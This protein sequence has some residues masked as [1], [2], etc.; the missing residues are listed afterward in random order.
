MKI[1][2]LG[3]LSGLL[4]VGLLNGQLQTL[5]DLATYKAQ[6]DH[7]HQQRVARLTAPEGWLSLAGLFWLKEGQ[8]TFGF[9]SGHDIQFP[10]GKQTLRLGRFILE[11][12]RV[13]V[14]LNPSAEV[15][16]DSQKVNECWLKDDSQ[17]KPSR[18]ECGPYLWYIIKR[19]T[20]L[21]VRL[22]DREN[23]AIKNF[24]GIER[25]PVQLK[26]RILAH[27]VPYDSV[28]TVAVPTVLGTK[29]PSK[30][31][32]ELA[33]RLQGQTFRLQV[34]AETRHEPLFVIFG[35]ATNGEETYGAGRFL[36]VA[37]PNVQGETIIDF[38]KA[39]NPP[40]AFTPYATCPLPP[41][42]NILPIR[43][44]AGEKAYTASIGH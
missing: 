43:V 16:V 35:D 40:C 24:K 3:I 30:S 21:G 1:I 10:G 32:G 9:G 6:I 27:F 15:L 5:P 2:I 14:K 20:R 23:P 31:P 13:K 38:N 12:G 17:G 33:F 8:N 37:A 42:Q 41:A 18:L 36:E 25:F 11:N 7:W 26:W 44:T 28:R 19:G 4:S 39:Y 29:A 22:K 34:L